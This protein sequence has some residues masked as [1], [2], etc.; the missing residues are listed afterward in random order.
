MRPTNRPTNAPT[1]TR[2]E[3]A[4]WSNGAPIESS[5]WGITGWFVRLKGILGGSEGGTNNVGAI[6]ALTDKF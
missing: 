6:A 3:L 4:S 2:T 5:I 1:T